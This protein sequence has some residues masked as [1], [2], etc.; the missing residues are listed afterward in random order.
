MSEKTETR[1]IELPRSVLSRVETRLPY[2][3][4]DKSSDYVAYILEE[5]LTHVEQEMMGTQY[6]MIDEDEVENRL[7]ALG[8]LNE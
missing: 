4:W 7:E 2:T 3:K 1:S 8:Y 6:D 5:A